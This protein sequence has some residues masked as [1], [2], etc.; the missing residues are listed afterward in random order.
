MNNLRFSTS[1]HILTLLAYFDKQY[2]N[3]TVIAGSIGINPV[4]VRQELSNLKKVGLI[5]SRNGKDGG[6][7]LAV[8]PA[9]I[10]MYDI[11]RVVHQGE[12]FQKYNAGNPNCEVG[13]QINGHLASLYTDIETNY[14]NKLKEIRLSDFVSEFYLNS[15]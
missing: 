7:T 5:Q 13:K 9:E 2:L 4:V 12:L 15:N 6:C 3:S 11:W 8:A 14:S 10:L 1:I